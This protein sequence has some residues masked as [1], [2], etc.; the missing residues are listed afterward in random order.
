M[1]W[2]F[3]WL[4]EK[5]AAAFEW[6]V[7]MLA[8]LATWARDTVLWMISELLDLVRPIFWAIFEFIGLAVIWFIQGIPVP[9]WF[10]GATVQDAINAIPSEVFW[11]VQWIHLDIGLAMVFG[12]LALRFLIRRLPVIG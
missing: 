10:E 9:S 5:F 3:S 4:W 11:L 7:E 6:L 12:A 2:L 8:A 1:S